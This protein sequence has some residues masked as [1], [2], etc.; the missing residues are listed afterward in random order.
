MSNTG[1][2]GN[3]GGET[4]FSAGE[5]V[6]IYRCPNKKFDAYAVY[7]NTVPAGALRGYGLTQTVFAVESAMDEL[8]S[9]STWTRWSRRRNIVRPGRP[10]ARLGRPPRGRLVHRGRPFG[11]ID[12][13]DAALR[14]TADDDLGPDWRVGTGAASSIHETAPPT[15][16]IS[17][18]WATLREDGVYE[19]AVGTVEFGEGTSTAHVQI[20]ATRWGLLR[21]GYI[22][23]SPI[24]T[25]TGSTR[26]PSPAGACSSQATL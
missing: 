23:C 15:D 2:Y 5:S 14:R 24:P 22:L 19:I 20:A 18:A 7:T 17:E 11:L 8:A 12:L 16:H 4:L 9:R 13:V 26:E 21:R 3:H 6:A 1:A 10:P 25:A